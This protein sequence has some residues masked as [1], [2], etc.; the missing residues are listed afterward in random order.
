MRNFLKGFLLVF[1]LSGCFPKAKETP[2]AIFYFDLKGYFKQLA[3][4]LNQQNPT[5]SKT[6]SKNNS[7]ESKSLKINNWNEEFALFISADIN[8]AAWKDSYSKDSSATKIVYTTKDPDL[9]TQKIIIDL[10]KG[11]PTHFHIE[12][13]VDNLLYHTA[14]HLEFYPDSL[15][16]IKKSQKVVLLGNNNYKI[17][18]K[19]K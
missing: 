8:K 12:T 16:E 4:R 13:K 17:I 11:K 18:G 6:V 10:T 14:E 5:I 9:K 3:D 2:R 15:Y 7:S 1:L 19:L